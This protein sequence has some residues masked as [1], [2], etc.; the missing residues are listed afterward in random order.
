MLEQLVAHWPVPLQQLV[1][2]CH[3]MGGL[4]A[5]SALHQAAACGHTWPARLG[6]I[7]FLGTPHH[8]APLERAGNWVDILLGGTPYAAPLARLGKVRSAGI[9]DLR[10]G[11][12]LAADTAGHDRFARRADSRQHVP[13]PSGVRCFTAATRWDTGPAAD[14]RTRTTKLKDR[15]IGDGLVP[16]ASALGQHPEPARCLAF[17]PAHQWVGSGIHHMQLLSDA[18]VYAQ[19]RGW[20]SAA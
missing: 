16:L 5:R 12:L 19:I 13:L 1:L 10:H 15:F 14:S 11:N 9:T 6:D 2:V 17:A 7:V 3:S 18:Q 20:L 4:L 8:G